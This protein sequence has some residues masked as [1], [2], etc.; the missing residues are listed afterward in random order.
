MY[1]VNLTGMKVA[2]R[3]FHD[4]DEDDLYALNSDDRVTQWLS[5]DSRTREQTHTALAGIIDRA[6][7]EPRTE[8]YLAFSR[9]GGD[10]VIGAARLGLNGVNAAKLGFLVHGDHW[11]KGYA[12]D[13]AR[14]VITFGFRELGLHRI[15]AAI[16]PENAASIAVVEKLGFQFEG[17]LRHHVFTNGAWRDSVLY[18]L[19]ASEWPTAATR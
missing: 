12:S 16:C 15:S 7:Q 13:A 17:R 2:L 4:T 8:Y 9:L 5:Y 3:E 14:T 1:P 19:L 18:S 6:R 10:Q 11:R